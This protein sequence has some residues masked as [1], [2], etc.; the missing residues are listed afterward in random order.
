MI[1]I[2]SHSSEHQ[3]CPISHL[4]VMYSEWYGVCDFVVLSVVEVCADYGGV[5]VFHVCLNFGIVYGVGV[6]VNVCV[7]FSL[8]FGVVCSVVGVWGVVI[9]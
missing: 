8:R 1:N 3:S 2:V 9:N 6:C 5:N 7:V 4:V